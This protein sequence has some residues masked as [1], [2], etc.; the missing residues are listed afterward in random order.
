M[1]LFL[2]LLFLIASLPAIGQ[3]NAVQRSNFDFGVSV[4]DVWGY[5]APDGTEY[6]LVGLDT[7]V[8]VISLADP[9]A[10]DLIGVTN[11]VQSIWRD[12]K[13]YRDYAYVV[14]DQRDDGLVIIDLRQLPD[15]F[16]VTHVR[17]TVPGFNRPFLR[18][19]NLN[20]DTTRGL[21][22]T[23][24]GDPNINAGGALIFDLKADPLHPTVIAT[25]PPIYSHDVYVQD[26]ILYASE[27]YEGQLAIY[28][29]RDLNDITELGRVTTPYTFTHNAWASGDGQTVFTT[30]EQANASVAA[31][32]IAD[33]ANIVLLDEYRPLS[34]L[35]T[36]TIPHNVHV[37]DDY[38]SISYYT[39]GLR[40]VDA[41]VPDNLVEVANYD[42]WPGPDGGF[43]GDWG[44]YPFLPSGLT[45]VSD[46]STGLYVID[47]DYIRAAR[48]AGT[49]IDSVTM[50][51][52]NGASVQILA[53]QPN[54]T[55]SDPLGNFATGIA[56][57]GTYR[58]AVSAPGYL[59]DTIDVTLV[60]GQTT[61]LNVALVDPNNM[62]TA[63]RVPSA[64]PVTATLAPNPAPGAAVL[65]YDMGTITAGSVRIYTAT[66]S[67]VAEQ[68]ITRSAG[69]MEI[70]DG[71]PSGIYILHLM[72]EGRALQTLRLVKH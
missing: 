65:T 61:D 5:V 10:P 25:G 60:N 39:D 3:L 47:V 34:S 71:Y 67:L 63:V 72:A 23:A 15:T 14:S 32:D 55:Q 52:I 28:D 48:V 13:T 29:T 36:K 16:A 24:G 45:L 9:D 27:L 12:I 42:T 64:P 50:D 20:I 69:R 7:G 51:P 18:A 19:H 40:V 43:D 62:P 66:G 17:D 68:R 33:P 38:L 8:A 11:G 57:A 30:D 35:N 49:V 6:A 31:Y 54:A 56:T 59:P 1:K 37:I 2:P 70:A 26:G 53:D 46:R 21:L 44:A 22:F 4:N 58:L 41:S